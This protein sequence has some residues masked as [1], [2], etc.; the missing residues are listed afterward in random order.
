M[1]WH[2]LVEKAIVNGPQ[3]P[4]PNRCCCTALMFTVIEPSSSASSLYRPT[5]CLRRETGK[6]SLKRLSYMLTLFD[7]ILVEDVTQWI[8][9]L[10]CI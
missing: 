1:P 10:L 3:L 2:R 8:L 4:S 5:S 6:W 7:S 9:S